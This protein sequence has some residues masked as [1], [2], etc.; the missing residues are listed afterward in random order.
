M[1]EI[2]RWPVRG[3]SAAMLT[4][5]V[6]PAGAAGMRS[7]AAC[8]KA[9][10]MSERSRPQARLRMPTAAG[11]RGFSTLPSGTRQVKARVVPKLSVMPGCSAEST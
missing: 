8:A 5:L 7:G 11:K 3:F 1:A 9:P 2:E 6:A 10:K 4:M